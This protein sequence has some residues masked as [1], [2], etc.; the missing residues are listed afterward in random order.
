MDENDER[1]EF[2]I[3][4]SQGEWAEIDR[5]LD[6]DPSLATRVLGGGCTLLTTLAGYGNKSVVRKLLSMGADPN[7][8][9]RAG[10]SPL[11]AAC[12]A[13]FEGRDTLN[14]IVGLLDAGADPDQ[15]AYLG[16]SPLHWAAAWGLTE[17]VELFLSRGANPTLLSQDALGPEDTFQIARRNRKKQVIEVL[18]KWRQG[19][20]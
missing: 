8:K 5:R 1:S 16:Q 11:L 10:S 17:Y 7:F 4:A 2:E 19:R 18:E 12:E 13:A 15:P 9:D 14:L 20:S 6:Q 3:L